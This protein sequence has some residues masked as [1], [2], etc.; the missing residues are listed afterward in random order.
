VHLTALPL[1]AVCGHGDP[2][3]FSP[4]SRGASRLI[5]CRLSRCT[6]LSYRPV[7]HGD[8]G[9]ASG[10]R[11]QR[12]RP[13]QQ[14]PRRQ[15]AACDRPLAC[16]D[17]RRWQA[18]GHA[19]AAVPEQHGSVLKRIK[20]DISDFHVFIGCTQTGLLRIWLVLACRCT[21]A[22]SQRRRPQRAPTTV[23][24]S[25]RPRSPARAAVFRPTLTPRSTGDSRAYVGTRQPSNSNI[26]AGVTQTPSQRV[27]Q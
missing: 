20:S 24:R 12:P 22:F 10:A 2:V 19:H 25:P 7:V 21:W 14:L 18:G 8:G 16:A 26:G 9:G 4:G 3:R 13:Q 5:C 15:P 27:C 11:P 23:R 6:H 17:Q 1:R